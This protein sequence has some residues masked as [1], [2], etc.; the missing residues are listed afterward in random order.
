M[1]YFDPEKHTEVFVDT[2]SSALGAAPAQKAPETES[3]DHKVIAYT[4][5]ALSDAESHYSQTEQEAL[6]LYWAISHF[7]LYLYS[8]V[9]SVITDHKLLEAIF[10]KPNSRPRKDQMLAAQAPTIQFDTR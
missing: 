9:F 1:A 2:S 3:M 10:N 5:R 8:N 7:H 4:S 6:G